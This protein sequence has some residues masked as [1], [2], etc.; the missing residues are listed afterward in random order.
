MGSHASKWYLPLTR[1][2][3]RGCYIA[4]QKPESSAYMPPTFWLELSPEADWRLSQCGRMNKGNAERQAAV[5][6]NI[7]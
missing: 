1:A 6:S 3:Y 4:L 5:A 2:D 7:S